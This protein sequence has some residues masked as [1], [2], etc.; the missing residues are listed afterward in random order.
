MIGKVAP[1]KT[2]KMLADGIF[3]SKLSYLISLWGGCEKYLIKSL[4]IVQNKAARVVTKLAWHTPTHALLSQCGW[5][6]VHQLAVHH[7]VALVHKILSSGHPK[8]LHNLF[9]LE[10]KVKTRHADLNLI[11]PSQSQAPEHELV[12]DSFRWRAM[13]N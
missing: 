3:I 4:Q 2:R 5:L 8:Y 10:Y 12:T 9:S 6:S 13:K 7:S 11:K 1:F